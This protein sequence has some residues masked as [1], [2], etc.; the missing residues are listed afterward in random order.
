MESKLQVSLSF[1]QPLLL[2]LLAGLALLGAVLRLAGWRG[3]EARLLVVGLLILA[4]AGPRL[5]RGRSPIPLLVAVE[6]GLARTEAGLAAAEIL[7]HHPHAV[8]VGFGQDVVPLGEADRAGVGVPR[9]GRLFSWAAD[10]L[11]SGGDLLLVTSGRSLDEPHLPPRLR[12]LAWPQADPEEGPELAVAA[13]RVPTRLWSGEA[14]ELT[15]ELASSGAG[16]AEVRVWVGEEELQERRVQV[17]PGRQELVFPLKAGGPGLVSL[18]VQVSAPWD[19]RRENDLHPAALVVYELPP[20]L[21]LGEPA[22]QLEAALRD[23]GFPVEA[24]PAEALP[25]NLAWLSRFGALVLNDVE[26]GRL[27][28]DQQQ[29]VLHFASS[30][31]GAVLAGGGRSSFTVGGYRDSVLEQALPVISEPPPQEE[32]PPVALLLV[33]DRSASMGTHATA[34]K[35]ALAREAAILAT[36]V[37][38][39]QDQLGVLAF[40]TSTEWIVPLQPLGEGLGLAQIQDQIARVSS[41]GGTDIRQA[42]RDGFEAMLEVEDAVRHVVLLTDGQD[43]SRR[44]ETYEQLVTAARGAGIT[45]SAMAIGG[46]ADVELLVRLAEWGQGRYY[47]AALPEDIPRLTLEESSLIAR[48]SRREGTFRAE[49][50]D[51]HPALHGYAPS[52]LP[53]LHGFL[54]T[55]PRPGT[56][57]ALQGPDGEPVL[58]FRRVGLGWSAAWLADWG[59]PWSADWSGWEGLAPFWGQVLRSILPRPGGSLL[60]VTAE[61]ESR[62]ATVEVVARTGEGEPVDL[63]PP[64]GMLARPGEGEQAVEMAQVGPG[65]YR[66]TLHGLEPGLYVLR[67]V[68]D[69][70]REAL[71]VD[72]PLAVP[73]PEELGVAHARPGLLEGLARTSGG[74]V[75]S[76]A[77]DLPS[78]LGPRPQPQAELAP[79]LLLAAALSLPLQEGLARWRDGRSRERGGWN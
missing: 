17:R 7:R 36:E 76:S 57:V 9:L 28:V 65:L 29:A 24:L 51:A 62:R 22:P 6:A 46:D 34:S 47:F 71:R 63:R 56:L 4:A 53:E 19:G 32:I 10:L 55:T 42:L 52:E 75:V 5:G 20:V 59:G 15:V 79:W 78:L 61:L 21:L 11:P 45:L 64:R 74:A 73:Y 66:L 50:K 33:L 1:A 44:L 13:A 16:A 49:V 41:S 25:S 68:Q 38:K 18:Q 60:E 2:W 35:M 8:G 58:A 40:N 48:L 12:L 67:L 23:Q 54:A 31:G 27:S 69:R 37:L 43:F 3:H 70:E 77:E 30:L 26:V 39:P 72:V 14:A